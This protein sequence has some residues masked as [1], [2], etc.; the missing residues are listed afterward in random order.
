M[1]EEVA[2]SEQKTLRSNGNEPQ[3][4]HISYVCIIPALPPASVRITQ[5]LEKLTT[6]NSQ[7]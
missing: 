2:P 1:M 3:G 5:V 4:L 7:L 6:Y